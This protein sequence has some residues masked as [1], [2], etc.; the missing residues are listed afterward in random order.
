MNDNPHQHQEEEKKR[1]GLEIAQ[2]WLYK[3]FLKSAYSLINK[4]LAILGVLK[5]AVKRLQRY[6]N[7]RELAGDVREQFST[8]IRLLRA[9]IRGEYKEVS[10]RNVALSI[11]ALLYFVSPFDILP[12]WLPLGFV[13]DAAL[14]AW[15]YNTFS[16]EFEAF[17]QWEDGMKTRIEIDLIAHENDTK[18]GTKT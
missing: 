4:P 13:D 10:L 17:R 11:A 2:G 16:D 18:E 7:V 5:Q 14:L 15:V 1:K 9:Y 8:L 12:D 3:A 6:E